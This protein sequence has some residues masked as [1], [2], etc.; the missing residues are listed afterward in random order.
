[1]VERVVYRERRRCPP[2][3]PREQAEVVVVDRVDRVEGTHLVRGVA[4]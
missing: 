4:C 3:Q 1:M 2:A